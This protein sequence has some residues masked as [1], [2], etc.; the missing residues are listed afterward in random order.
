MDLGNK[1]EES[2]SV[3]TLLPVTTPD[4]VL[5]KNPTIPA[6]IDEEYAALRIF[7]S[8]S[9]EDDEAEDKSIVENREVSNEE[10]ILAKNGIDSVLHMEQKIE[11]RVQFEEFDES[12]ED[13][14]TEA[15]KIDDDIR[16][17][18]KKLN[19]KGYE[20]LYSCSGHPSARLKSD[21]YRD[22]I[23]DGKL[24]ST[25]KIVFAEAYPFPNYPEGWEKKVLE[26]KNVGIY[27]K[28]PTF[29]IINGLPTD[30][31]YKWKKKYMYHLEKWV[32]ELPKKDELGNKGEEDLVTESVNDANDL[33]DDLLI[34][35]A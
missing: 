7:S 35:L 6:T 21:I 30:Q 14:F 33:L 25:A 26:E 16:D 18:I 27:V 10:D 34:D 15:A 2:A 29:R 19:D 22:G 1:L 3:G 11:E 28:P 9:N 5:S 8:E 20:T 12:A 32:D 23:K 13:F 4:Q 24:Y 17:I 31:F